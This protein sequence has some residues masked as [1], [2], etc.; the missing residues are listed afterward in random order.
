M[1][2]GVGMEIIYILGNYDV[3]LCCVCGLMLLVM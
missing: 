2:C 1:L 3:L